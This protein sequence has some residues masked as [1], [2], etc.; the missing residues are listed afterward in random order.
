M[1][2]ARGFTLAEVLVA[3]TLISIICGLV[4]PT[5]GT[6]VAAGHDIIGLGAGGQPEHQEAQNRVM[7]E[8]NA[9]HDDIQLEII[10]A[11]F[12][13]SRD[14][15]ST[16]IA[17]GN[18]PDIIGPVGIGGSNDYEGTFLD[19]DPI[20]EELDYDLS[21]WDPALVDFYRDPEEGLTALPFATY[22]SFIYFNRDLFDAA[23]VDYP[24]QEFGAPYA[25]GDEWNV[26]K[27]RE[28]AMQL[29]LDA[30]GNNA[31]SDD[32]DPRNIVQF[33]YAPQWWGDDIRS[34]VTSPFGAG[35]F[36]DGESGQ[37]VMPENWA[38]GIRWIYRAWHEDYFAPNYEYQQSDMLL[39]GNCLLYTSPSPRDRTRSRMPSSA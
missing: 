31:L 39:N 33:G 36:W 8:F 25:D 5:S 20:V 10:V 27:L 22:P 34:A 15:L 23:G 21:R 17:A 37:A 35:S 9:T 24:P 18:A 30:N 28:I 19:L 3:T 26:E 12:D 6:V 14:T 1:R 29:T 4:R 13:V 7:E 38:E 16:L 11:D 2:R 32:F